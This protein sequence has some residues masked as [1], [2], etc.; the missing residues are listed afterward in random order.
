MSSPLLSLTS[1][2]LILLTSSS[3]L[4]PLELTERLKEKIEETFGCEY[5]LF[6]EFTGLISWCKGASIGWHSDDNRSYLKQ[7][8]FASGEPVTVAPSAGDV[9][10]Y[11]ADDRNIHSVDE[12]TD[13]ERLTLALWF[14]RDSSHDEDSKLLSRLS[15]CTSHEVCLPL[16]AST[17]MYWFC[18]H[19]DGSNQNIGFDVCVARLH[20]LGFDVHSLQGE[21]HSTDASEQLMGPLQL[22]KGGKLLTRKFANIL[23]ALQVVQF[24]HW[25]ASELVT[26][27]VENDTLEE[28]KAMSHSQLETI[29]AL[30]SVFLLDENLVATTFGYSCSGEDRKDSLDLTGIALA[31]TSWEEY[32]CK[33][34]KELL[35]SLPQWKTYQTIHKVESD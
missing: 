23:H 29:N 32:S 31:V 4:S 33:L 20:L 24:Y 19:Q 8:D 2:P 34:L 26:S 5:E 25:K 35:S 11:T 18:P 13:G 14:S 21:D 17:N 27:N 22:A 1:L 7:R 16:P 15:Q 6:I 9:I 10:M 12:V 3:L 30:K 28:V